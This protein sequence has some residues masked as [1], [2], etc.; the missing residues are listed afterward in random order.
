MPHLY[1]VG[2][3]PPMLIEADTGARTNVRYTQYV[4]SVFGS[5]FHKLFSSAAHHELVAHIS[6]AATTKNGIAQ[7]EHDRVC[8][9]L[10]AAV[11]WL[12]GV[13]PFENI[14]E[15]PRCVV[16]DIIA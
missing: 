14:S 4:Y 12:L 10:L 1:K 6:T 13:P 9:L 16:V 2:E 11:A 15:S 3:M 5:K 8:P 7:Q